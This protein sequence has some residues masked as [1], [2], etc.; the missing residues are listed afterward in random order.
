MPSVF[1][2]KFYPHI[3]RNPNGQSAMRAFYNEL[4]L[5]DTTSPQELIG[6]YR[7]RITEFDDLYS[8]NVP[9]KFF[10]LWIKGKNIDLNQRYIEKDKRESILA[11]FMLAYIAQIYKEVDLFEVLTLMANRIQNENLAFADG[12]KII[13]KVVQMK[14]P[15]LLRSLLK[16]G[17]NINTLTERGDKFLPRRPR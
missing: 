9:Y 3:K 12:L 16:I 13:H 6:L 14:N 11:R 7:Q 2:L 17:F 10:K 4:A 1:T 15:P 5:I 8:I